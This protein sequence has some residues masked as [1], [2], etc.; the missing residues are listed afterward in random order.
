MSSPIPVS[1]AGWN[2]WLM[3]QTASHGFDCPLHLHTSR[4][5]TAWSG[6]KNVIFLYGPITTFEWSKLLY[7][8]QT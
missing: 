4:L 5:V 7:L 3:V 8:V 6:E 1:I 2:S